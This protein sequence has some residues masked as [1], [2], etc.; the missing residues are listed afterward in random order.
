MEFIDIAKKRYSVRSYLSKTVDEG[1]LLKVLEAGRVAPSA[2]NIQPCH[3]IVIKDEMNRQKIC[4]AY[5]RDWLKEA[6]VIIVVCGD[7]STSWKRK[8]GKDHCDI[9]IAI[10]V[11]HMTLQAAELELGT[12][13][14]CNFDKQK[15]S[16]VLT[17]PENLEPMVILPLGYPADTTDI[18]RHSIKR[19]S[20]DSIVHWE[21]Y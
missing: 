15:C 6:P 18:N 7:H 20:L 1:K 16:E 5:H 13:W 14:V 11:D 4:S 10:A 21:K 9:D 8:D 12:C 3:F 19:K 17:L 2:V